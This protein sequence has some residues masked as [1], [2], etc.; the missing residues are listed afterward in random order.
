MNEERENLKM[1]RKL[2]RAKFAERIKE[3]GFDRHGSGM[4]YEKTDF[5]RKGVMIIDYFRFG[6]LHIEGNM[7][8]TLTDVERLLFE[9]RTQVRGD[10]DIRT[11][12]IATISKNLGNIRANFFRYW[13][14]YNEADIEETVDDIDVL[15]KDCGLAFLETVDTPEK[16]L[17]EILETTKRKTKLGHASYWYEKGFVLMMLQKNRDLFEE[18]LPIFEH[19][20]K[21]SSA[22]WEDY[23]RFRDWVISNPR[24][25]T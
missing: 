22:V 10:I 19:Y 3:H 12:N 18:Y 1:L 8:V 23:V 15:V 11:P 4:Y 9:Y 17:H 13:N 14:N 2:F 25:A 20:A 16:I 5:G 24:W 6:A 21:N 7:A